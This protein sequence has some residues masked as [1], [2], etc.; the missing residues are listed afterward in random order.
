MNTGSPSVTSHVTQG[1]RWCL[2]AVG[3][4]DAGISKIAKLKRGFKVKPLFNFRGSIWGIYNNK[5]IEKKHN[6]TVPIIQYPD[7]IGVFEHY[8]TIVAAKCTLNSQ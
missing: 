2:S 5:I 6:Q 1:E 8:T 7:Y 4:F 3:T